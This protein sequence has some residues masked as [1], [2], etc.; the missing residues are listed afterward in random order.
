MTPENSGTVQG[1]HLSNPTSGYSLR[2][3]PRVPHLANKCLKTLFHLCALPGIGFNQFIKKNRALFSWPYV[4]GALRIRR[5]FFCAE[6]D[7]AYF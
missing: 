3:R 5:K 2:G 4:P 1:W 6:E 7:M